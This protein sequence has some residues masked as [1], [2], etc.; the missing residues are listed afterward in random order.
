MEPLF[1]FLGGISCCICSWQLEREGGVYV[2]TYSV[3]LY[4][5][6]IRGI[7]YIIETEEVSDSEYLLQLFQCFLFVCVFQSTFMTRRRGRMKRPNLPSLKMR[8]LPRKD[9][10]DPRA[11]R[12]HDPEYAKTWV[13]C[14]CCSLYRRRPSHMVKSSP[15]RRMEDYFE[16][17]LYHYYFHDFV[18]RLVMD[19][20]R[21]KARRDQLWALLTMECEETAADT[22]SSTACW[23]VEGLVSLYSSSS[24]LTFHSAELFCLFDDELCSHIFITE[25]IQNLRLQEAVLRGPC[26]FSLGWWCTC[27]LHDVRV[28]SVAHYSLIVVFKGDLIVYV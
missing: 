27:F 26:R 3:L 4:S 14:H 20:W 1:C 7:E 25:F 11:W 21:S 10:G 13:F 24:S 5:L 9:W 15:V 12:S 6:T 18:P 19:P 2:V 17:I 22:H 23:L 28:S 8:L 16:I